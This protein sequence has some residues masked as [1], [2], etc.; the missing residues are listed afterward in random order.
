MIPLAF[1]LYW[2]G[3]FSLSHFSGR[4]VSEWL[5]HL[6]VPALEESFSDASL[7]GLWCDEQKAGRDPFQQPPIDAE[8]RVLRMN[9]PPLFFG[10]GFMG[11]ASK[12]APIFGVSLAVLFVFSVTLLAGS[13]SLGSACIW[14]ALVC[15][16]V[17]LFACERGNFDIL[18]FA[19]LSVAVAMRSREFIAGA[20]IVSAAAL[21]LFPIVGLLAIFSR[22]RKGLL[23]ALVGAVCFGAY[24]FLIWDFL[25]LIFGSLST[26]V[27]CA[28]GASVVTNQLGRSEWAVFFKV[29]SLISGI[30]AGVLGFA[31]ATSSQSGSYQGKSFFAALI[32]LPVFGVLFLSGVQFDYKLFFLF[33]AVPLSI[34]LQNSPIRTFNIAARLWM[35]VLFFYSYWMFFS[36]ESCLR[37]LLL[38]QFVSWGLFLLSCFLFGSIAKPSLVTCLRRVR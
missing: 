14:V 35:G 38:K 11:L 2:A 1:A 22:G 36:G 29:G 20:L 4:P 17:S 16:P 13:C 19:L 31:V 8:G 37:N 32:G 9:Y 21:K 30:L 27:T 5:V 15:S 3:L 28:F 12:T 10:F 34:E 7:V 33:L 6:G 23:A 25:P 18:V 26:N 24:M